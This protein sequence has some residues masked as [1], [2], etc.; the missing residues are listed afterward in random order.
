MVP[1]FFISFAIESNSSGYVTES[2]TFWGNR[3]DDVLAF[4]LYLINFSLA[5]QKY[6]WFDRS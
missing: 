1:K 2:V 5:V 4:C 6:Y 3:A